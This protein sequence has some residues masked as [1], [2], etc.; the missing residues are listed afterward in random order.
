MSLAGQAVLG[1]PRPRQSLAAAFHDVR[2]PRD[3]GHCFG[4]ARN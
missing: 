1:A 3:R 2:V 4:L